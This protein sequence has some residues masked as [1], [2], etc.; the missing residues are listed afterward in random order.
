[1]PRSQLLRESMCALLVMMALACQGRAASA[2]DARRSASYDDLIALFRDWRTF[3]KPQ[4]ADGVPD[5]TVSA[6][7]AQR[8]ALSDYQKRLAAIDSSSWPVPQR[9]DYELV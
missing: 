5:Y 8:T 7:S 9:V 1:M 2:P 6:M 4:V 3:Q